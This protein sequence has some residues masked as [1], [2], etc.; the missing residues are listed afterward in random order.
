MAC[1]IFFQTLADNKQVKLK[2]KPELATKFLAKDGDAYNV[3]DLVSWF[4]ENALLHARLLDARNEN[5]FY[6]D[7][8]HFVAGFISEKRKLFPSA[9]D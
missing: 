5:S 1:F 6:T 2:V 7:R 3:A 8:F 4:R 9:G